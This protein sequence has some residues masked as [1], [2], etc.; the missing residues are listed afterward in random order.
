[1]K[2]PVEL[3]LLAD[4]ELRAAREALADLAG[5]LLA[6]PPGD[7]SDPT[8][9]TGA[10]GQAIFHRFVAQAGVLPADDHHRRADALLERAVALA[11]EALDGCSIAAG[12]AGLAWAFLLTEPAGPDLDAQLAAIDEVVVE[13]V[14]ADVFETRFDVLY[15]LAGVGLY[16]LR[17]PDAEGAAMAEGVLARLRELARPQARGVAWQTDPDT[18]PDAVRGLHLADEKDLGM[19]HGSAGVITA[20]AGMVERGL[21][22]EGARALLDDAVA[23]VVSQRLADPSRGLFPGHVGDG[24]SRH[25]PR[26]AWCIGDAGLG[27]ALLHAARASRRDDLG[28][29]ARETLRSAASRFAAMQGVVD[30]GICHGAMGLAQ[31]YTRAWRLTGDPEYAEVARRWVREGLAIKRPD[32]LGFGLESWDM[33]LGWLPDLSLLSGAAGVGLALASAVTTMEPAWDGV[34][35]MSLPGV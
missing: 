21:G 9:F 17:R 11:P 2:R 19:A 23:W 29:L 31:I 1:M 18:L 15:G 32:G 5:S 8:L 34:F 33:S 35:G 16:A 30:A 6:Q 27:L 7:A 10:T 26:V 24:L 3:P 25:A 28:A 12:V 20:L 14:R 4:E 13:Q 22:A